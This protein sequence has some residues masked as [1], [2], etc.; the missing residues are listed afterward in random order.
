MCFSDLKRM[1]VV[2]S[3]NSSLDSQLRSIELSYVCEGEKKGFLVAAKGAPEVMK[4][5]MTSVPDDYDKVRCNTFLRFKLLESNVSLRIQIA[6][7]HTCHGGRV[8]AI[9]Y[10]ALGT[11]RQSEMYHLTRDDV[12]KELTFGGNCVNSLLSLHETS[13]QGS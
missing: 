1:S 8:L 4:G 9:G 11:D 12:E 3:T 7:H 6:K 5:L 2:M 13:I 10:R